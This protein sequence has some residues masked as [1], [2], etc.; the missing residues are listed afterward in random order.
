G[1]NGGTF[2]IGDVSFTNDGTIN[3]SNGDTVNLDSTG[4]SNAG[5]INVSGGTLN[6]ESPFTTAQLGTIDHSG[7]AIDIAGTLNNAGATLNIGTG[8]ALGTLTLE[9]NG[10]IENGT[11]AD[12]GSG[13]TFSSGTLSGVTY[14]GPLN[15]SSSSLYVSNGLTLR[16]LGGSGPGTLNLTGTYSYL[17][18][19]GTETRN[20]ATINLG[21]SGTGYIYNDDASAVAVLTFG[22]SLTINQTGP[23]A[24]L[25]GYDDRTGSG[26]VNDGTT[27]AGF[28]GG[29]FTIGDVSFTND[30]TIN[31]SNGDTVNVT[32]PETGSG[33]YVIDS[34]SSLEFNSSVASGATI[35]FEGSTGTL[36]LEQP[37]TFSG[38]ISAA[39]G[40]LGL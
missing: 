24:D 5:T 2:T 20:N 27:D 11:I 19:A 36:L 31:V 8:T 39:S 16:G 26:I 25:A 33:S 1:F 3:V 13:L 14:Q 7:G 40:T 22:P 10:T 6:L 15:L 30:G 12:A 38:A 9:S 34:G 17:Y 23:S 29:T 21:S 18:L 37:S 28:N 35:Y 4:W 32:S